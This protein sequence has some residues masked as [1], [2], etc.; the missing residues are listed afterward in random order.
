MSD[1]DKKVIEDFGK[2]WTRFTQVGSVSNQELDYIFK[3]YFI[4]ILQSSK[5]NSFN[6]FFLYC[7]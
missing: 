2:E 1:K 4:I 3:G 5:S 7:K 6:S